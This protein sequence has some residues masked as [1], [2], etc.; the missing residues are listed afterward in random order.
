MFSGPAVHKVRVTLARVGAC[1]S[2]FFLSNGNE[3]FLGY[4][5]PINT[6][7]NNKS[8]HFPGEVTVIIYTDN[9]N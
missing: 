7:F 1:I 6:I 2:V 5:D 3:M 9:K 4:F 8:K